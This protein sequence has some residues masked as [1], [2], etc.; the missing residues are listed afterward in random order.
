MRANTSIDWFWLIRS[1]IWLGVG[2]A[3]I[4]AAVRSRRSIVT[5]V[6]IPAGVFTV[7]AALAALSTSVVRT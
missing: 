1:V 4:V 5:V 7:L 3:V 6:G 2:V